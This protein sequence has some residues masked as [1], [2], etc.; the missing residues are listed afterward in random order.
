M[1]LDEAIAWLKGERSCCNYTVGEDKV[2]E[3]DANLTQQAYWIVKA[4]KEGLL[5]ELKDANA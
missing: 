4:H 1:K 5:K 2:T 3:I